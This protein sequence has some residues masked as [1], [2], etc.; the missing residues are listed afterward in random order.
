MHYLHVKLL[1]M[2]YLKAFLSIVVAADELIFWHWLGGPNI[3]RPP[4]P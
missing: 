1:T 4:V 2:P 3:E